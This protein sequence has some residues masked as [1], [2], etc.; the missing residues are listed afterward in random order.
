M[1]FK[2]PIELLQDAE[3]IKKKLSKQMHQEEKEV[4]QEQLMQIYQ[5]RDALYDE[6]QALI[7]KLFNMQ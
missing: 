3:N 5:Q 4:L 1:T 7:E 2:F 6:K